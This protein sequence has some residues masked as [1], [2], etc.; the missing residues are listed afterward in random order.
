MRKKFLMVSLIL[1]LL[2]SSCAIGAS[3][4]E[5][6]KWVKNVL[7]I[8]EME[9]EQTEIF[10]P[11]DEIKIQEE[12]KVEE[13]KKEDVKQEVK[14]E[15]IKAET[16]DVAKEEKKVEEIK[17]EV[18]K[19]ETKVQDKNA[20]VIIVKET[21]KVS[22]A[23]SAEDP[24][25]DNLIFQYTSPLDKNGEWQT[26][27]GDA[28][29]Y[30]VTI[31]VSDSKLS[32]SEDVLVIVNKKEEAPT[33]TKFSPDKLTLTANEN[34]EIEF[35]VV[36][37]D[38]NNDKVTYSWILDGK[39]VSKSEKYLY[40]VNY[41]AAGKHTINLVVSDGTLETTKEWSVEVKN[42]NRAP[43]LEKLKD[44]KVKET[45]T[46]KISP[47]ATDADGDKI[48]FTISNPIGDDG[49]WKTTYDN[50]GEYNVKVTASDGT[51]E[52]SQ[53]IKVTVENVNRAPV[54]KDI[55]QK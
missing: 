12:K 28:G 35:S 48:K 19:E 47:K 9:Q 20:K 44:I 2:I 50:A 23:I 31:T 21:E 34:S 27:Y 6:G 43:E 49:E 32:V 42:V 24:D 5:F 39:E 16:K 8:Q 14:V 40:K 1:V 33:I 7:G 36:A 41:D 15:E 52:A 26:N 18:K 17:Q 11:I 30:T 3:A 37:T 51:D 4:F 55:V 46:I 45:E 54:I 29:E 25:K 10:V 13:V 53:T 38:K 22:L